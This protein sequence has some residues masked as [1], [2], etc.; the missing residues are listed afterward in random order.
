MAAR[1]EPGRAVDEV[2]SVVVELERLN[3]RL[4]W[5]VLRAERFRFGRSAER[6]SREELGQLFLALGGDQ[7]TEAAK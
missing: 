1:G 3:D 4:A 5:R 6:P 7:A 2:L